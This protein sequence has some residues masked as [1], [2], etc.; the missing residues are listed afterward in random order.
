MYLLAIIILLGLAPII[1]IGAIRSSS[2]TGDE[3]NEMVASPE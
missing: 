1:S 2:S 3:P